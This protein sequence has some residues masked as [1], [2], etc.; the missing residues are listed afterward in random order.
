M[1]DS[2]I[3]SLFWRRAEQGISELELRYGPLLHRIAANIL[4]DA[5]DA[6]ECV[7]DAYL[8]LWNTIPPQRPERLCAYACRIVRNLALARR[9]DD[10]AQKRDSRLEV[11]LE[12]LAEGL[13]ARSLEQT[14][15]AREL[16]R[17]I[18]AFLTGIDRENRIIFLRRYWFGDSVRQIAATL[19]L[20]QN[21]VSIRLSR[22]RKQLRMH[23]IREGYYYD[24]EKT[25][26]SAQ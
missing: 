3:V 22:T 6:Q 10:H 2:G 24:E 23:L 11:S 16:G 5:H 26:R 9:R 13:H 15:D 7:N 20:S 18:D 17:A 19:G 25:E 14:I 4:D 21:A 1:D 8:A 12:E